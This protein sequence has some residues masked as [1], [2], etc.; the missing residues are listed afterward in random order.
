MVGVIKIMDLQKVPYVLCYISAPN[1][2]AGHHPPTPP[3]ETPGHSQASLGQFLVGS[4]LL[5]PGCWCTQISVC[6]LQESVAPVLAALWWGK[7]PPPP[8]GLMPHPG[9]LHPEPLPLQQ[10]TADLRVT[11]S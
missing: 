5:S 9:L 6:F 7:W 10:S 11:Y 8:R 2:A 1:P 3:L 4:L